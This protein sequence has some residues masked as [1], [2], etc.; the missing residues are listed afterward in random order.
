MAA[1]AISEGSGSD[2]EG[3]SDY[4]GVS[5]VG[6]WT[7]LPELELGLATEMDA[8]EAYR[9]L[10][11]AVRS[12]ALLA[13]VIGL[14][15]LGMAGYALM[16]RR[17]QRRFAQASRMGRYQIE[18]K[19]GE[20]GMGKV[21]LARHALLRRPTALKVLD[22][23]H[24]TGEAVKRFEREVQ[25]VARLTHPNT[26]AVYDYGRTP[27]GTF[28]YAMEYLEGITLARLVESDGAQPEAR[29][30]H[31]LLQMAGSLAEAHTAKLIHR[32]LKPSNV[33]ICARGGL[34][35]Y[36]KVLDFGLVRGESD[37]VQLT[38]TRALTGTPQYLSP[39]GL[40]SPEAVDARSDIYQLGAIA[41]VLLTGRPV[42]QGETLVELLT[43][44]LHATPIPPSEAIGQPVSADLES[45]V[46]ACLAK[47][48]NER[49]SDGGALWTALEPCRVDGTWTH[50]DALHWWEDWSRVH[51][52]SLS[53]PG[54]GSSLPSGWEIELGTRSRGA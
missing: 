4:R 35:D 42:F 47:D 32:D 23:E 54:S 49:P 28:Y 44:H 33:M 12:A 34:L 48:P 6:A 53:E 18:E 39:E 9:G 15:I 17:S 20:G 1:A 5:V 8:D 41:Y 26:I 7:W 10:R 13:A 22:S 46:L 31:L 38:A 2:I 14:L 27:D 19:I 40:Q 45:L 50:L 11:R 36:V 3:Y 51:A 43:Q 21:F 52:G 29:V 25:A 37:D 24:A 16:L 30:K